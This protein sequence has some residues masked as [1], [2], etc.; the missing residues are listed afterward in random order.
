MNA[1]T[2]IQAQAPNSAVTDDE[3]LARMRAGNRAAGDIL[4]RRHAS[5]L[6]R[7]AAARGPK[8]DVEDAVQDAFL[9]LLADPTFQPAPGRIGSW[10]A[11]VVHR[12][13]SSRSAELHDE[14][15]TDA[16][17]MLEDRVPRG[18]PRDQEEEAPT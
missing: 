18:I 7:I 16:L 13:A 4:Y 8:A 11:S 17:A 3:L 10:L 1:V 14:S 5:M 6:R 15:P 9:I 2:L 12:R